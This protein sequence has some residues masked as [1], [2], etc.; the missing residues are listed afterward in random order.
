MIEGWNSGND[1]DIDKFIKD[2][3][4]DARNLK[5]SKLNGVH[6]L[7]FY[8]LTKRFGNSRI[9]DDFKN[10]RVREFSFY[11]TLW[12]DKL[13][14]LTWLLVEL[15]SLHKLLYSHKDFHS[16]NI[17]HH[18]SKNL[19]A[20]YVSDFG[21]SG[22]LNKQ[23]SENKICGVLPYIAPEVLNGNHVHLFLIFIVLV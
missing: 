6:S 12:K 16:G 13:F 22:P 5:L 17:L 1:N 4:Y 15:K 10:C 3:I 8:G 14:Y 7:R 9:Y 19:D 21:L 2:T 20:A 23:K 18:L 11:N